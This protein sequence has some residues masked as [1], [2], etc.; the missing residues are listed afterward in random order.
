MIGIA[1]GCLLPTLCSAAE[2]GR[3]LKITS[4]LGIEA[5]VPYDA[6][7]STDDDKL[8]RAMQNQLLLRID[9]NIYLVIPQT[10]FDKAELI[11]KKHIVTLLNGQKFT[12]RLD[13]SISYHEKTYSLAA[14]KMITVVGQDSPAEKED[15]EEKEPEKEQTVSIWELSVDAQKGTVY[16]GINPKFVVQYTSHSMVGSSTNETFVNEFYIQI[17]NEDVCVNPD[18]FNI[19]SFKERNVIITA[20]NGQVT[21]GEVFYKPYGDKDYWGYLVM[22]LVGS[23]G[24]QIVLTKL[25]CTM[26]KQ[27]KKPGA[28][29]PKT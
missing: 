21:T 10:L 9:N 26:K 27:Q 24:I 17:D 5:T 13:C 28:D 29:T 20:P 3:K 16:Q 23:N 22:D 15:P 14:A 7:I 1:M 25:N 2:D 19:I 8:S 11:N 6:D 12:G 18:D 4:V